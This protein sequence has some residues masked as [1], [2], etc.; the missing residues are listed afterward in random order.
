VQ[1]TEVRRV[2][3]ALH[4][5]EIIALPLNAPDAQLFVIQPKRLQARKLGWGLPRSHIDPNESRLFPNAIGLCLDAVA[6]GRSCSDG[7]DEAIISGAHCRG[8]QI[9]EKP[10]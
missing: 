1:K 8:D 4:G 9:E 10:S 2:D 3:V 7:T 6:R 5:L